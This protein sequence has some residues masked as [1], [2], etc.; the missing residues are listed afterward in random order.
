M[1][2][3]RGHPG[4]KRER[5]EDESNDIVSTFNTLDGKLCFFMVLFKSLSLLSNVGL[6]YEFNPLRNKTPATA[7]NDAERT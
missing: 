2:C 6:T 4:D 5:N 1:R 3:N 7:G